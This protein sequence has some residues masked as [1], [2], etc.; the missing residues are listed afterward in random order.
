MTFSLKFGESASSSNLVVGKKQIKRTAQK[1]FWAVGEGY[2]SATS[3]YPSARPQSN[4][5]YFVLFYG[6]IIAWLDMCKSAAKRLDKMISKRVFL[7][8]QLLAI[9]EIYP[10]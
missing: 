7:F 6:V 2:L 8:E 4:G 10:R 3:T 9:L 5:G 1:L